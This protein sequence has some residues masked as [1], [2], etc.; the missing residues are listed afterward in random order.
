[1][2]KVFCAMGSMDGSATARAPEILLVHDFVS[3]KVEG[4]N[5]QEEEEWL[6]CEVFV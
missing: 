5:T 3:M 1:M 2:H 4:T 6:G